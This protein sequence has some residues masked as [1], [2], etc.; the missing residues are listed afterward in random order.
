MVTSSGSKPYTH[1]ILKGQTH[2][3][4]AFVNFYK[5]YAS[6]KLTGKCELIKV[7]DIL[8]PWL[9]V[10]FKK[11]LST[12]SQGFEEKYFLVSSTQKPMRK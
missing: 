7:E 2:I 9:K 11:S 3:Y 5:K 10:L 4:L 1:T 12:L 8:I 6:D